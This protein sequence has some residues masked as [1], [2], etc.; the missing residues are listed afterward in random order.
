MR[1]LLLQQMCGVG[2]WKRLLVKKF[3]SQ[4]V[5]SPSGSCSE[6]SIDWHGFVFRFVRFLYFG[7]LGLLHLDEADGDKSDECAQKF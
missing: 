4:G 5:S 7:F 1:R 6:D 2:G 3:L